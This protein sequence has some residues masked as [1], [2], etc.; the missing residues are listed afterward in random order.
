MAKSFKRLRLWRNPQGFWEKDSISLR[1]QSDGEGFAKQ[2][3]NQDMLT[4]IT[5]IWRNRVPWFVPKRHWYLSWNV[6]RSR[7]DPVWWTLAPDWATNRDPIKSL[8]LRMSSKQRTNQG[9]NDHLIC[10]WQ[11]RVPGWQ[12]R[13]KPFPVYW[14]VQEIHKRWMTSHLVAR[15]GYGTSTRSQ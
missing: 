7:R 11:I 14:D 8:L 6:N 5:A 12:F 3:T 13:K 4:G 1:Y 10:D 15:L 2:D 9:W